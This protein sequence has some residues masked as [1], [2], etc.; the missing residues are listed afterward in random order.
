MIV[1]KVL[2]LSEEEVAK[3]VEAG[4]VLKAIATTEHDS[5]DRDGTDLLSALYVALS[6]VV[7]W[8]VP[9]E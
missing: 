5:I 9:E 1:S 7:N 4:K 2:T 8:P 6:N 3:L